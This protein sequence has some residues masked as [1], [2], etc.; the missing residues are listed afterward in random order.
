MTS[1]EALELLKQRIIVGKGIEFFDLMYKKYYEIIRKDLEILE[2]FIKLF[3]GEDLDDWI[4]FDFKND[5][6]DYNSEWEQLK[7]RI[8]EYLKNEIKT[9]NTTATK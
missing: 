7:R 4:E 1:K 6:L 9:N 3:E 5:D 8:K 2:D